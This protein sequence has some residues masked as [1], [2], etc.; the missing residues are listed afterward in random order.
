MDRGYRWN[1]ELKYCYS[2]SRLQQKKIVWLDLD[3]N[4]N[5]GSPKIDPIEIFSIHRI[6]E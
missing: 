1:F 3:Q 2:F 5:N 4:E 6:R